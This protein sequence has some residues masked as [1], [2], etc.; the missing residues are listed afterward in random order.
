M[1]GY[2]VPIGHG[3]VVDGSGAEPILAHL[4]IRGDR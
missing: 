3:L 1:P 2:D 4:A